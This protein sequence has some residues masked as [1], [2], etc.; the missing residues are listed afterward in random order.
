LDTLK[1]EHS[2]AIISHYQMPGMEGIAFLEILINSKKHALIGGITFTG[3]E[4][5][6][7]AADAL[8]KGADRHITKS[9]NPASQ[10]NELAYCIKELLGGEVTVLSTIDLLLIKGDLY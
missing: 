2:D 8:K 5:A 9:G 6:R 3:K 1:T 4:G 10:C 7:V